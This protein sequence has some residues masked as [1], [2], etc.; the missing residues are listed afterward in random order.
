VVE[1]A[2]PGVGQNYRKVGHQSSGCQAES[3]NC[4]EVGSPL[5]HPGYESRLCSKAGHRIPKTVLATSLSGFNPGKLPL[6]VANCPIGGMM[7]NQER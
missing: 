2:V 4:P 1:A 3:R 6:F 5:H 7:G